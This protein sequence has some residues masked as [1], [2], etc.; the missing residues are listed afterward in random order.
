MNKLLKVVLFGLF[1]SKL[2]SASLSVDEIVNKT[3]EVA[4]YQ[5]ND[6][7]ASVYME[8]IDKQGRKRTREFTML[9]KNIGKCCGEQ[10]YYVY[11]HRPADVN[12]MVYMVWKHTDRDDDRWLYLPA[13]DLVKRISAT[14]K[15]S[16]FVG[17]DF[18]YEDVSGRSINL[19]KHILL[20]TTKKF[21]VLKNVPKDPK[22]V[23]FSYFTMWIDKRTFLPIKVVFY[24]K[25]G[26]PHR[27]YEV[28]EVKIIQGYPTVTKSR[29]KN[30]QTKGVTNMTFS[31]IKYNINIPE[32]IFTERYLRVPPIRYLRAK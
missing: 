22:I 6:G 30:L 12:K 29:M 16:S 1:V 28:L 11:F 3:N 7:R 8:I 32:N 17:S 21:Y 19:D 9:R 10:K 27:V 18:V 14:D 24:D 13:L 20:K 23:E 5:G 31:R 25:Q 15:R 26:N 2:F 4:Y